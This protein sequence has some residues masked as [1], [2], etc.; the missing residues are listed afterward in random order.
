M[1]AGIDLSGLHATLPH[2]IYTAEAADLADNGRLDRAILVAWRYLL[3]DPS[4]PVAAAEVSLDPE[5]NPQFSH[6]NRGPF[7]AALP[8]AVR[9]AAALEPV[10]QQDFELRVIRIP[11]VYEMAVWLRNLQAG[12]DLF[13][14]MKPGPAFGPSSAR[15]PAVMVARD[16]QADL[17]E[18]ARRRLS[19]PDET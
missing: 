3:A 17:R 9:A 12:E 7:V 19:F 8:D 11:S 15:A 10:Q 14:P 18:K 1:L 5:G 4:G 13:V 2:P 16:F 6:L